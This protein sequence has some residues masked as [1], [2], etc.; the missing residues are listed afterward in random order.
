[1]ANHGSIEGTPRVQREVDGRR[2]FVRC[3]RFFHYLIDVTWII[4][5]NFVKP[6]FNTRMI[7]QMNAIYIFTVYIYR[8]T[9]EY[10]HTRAYIII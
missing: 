1:M 10:M 8:N 9:E 7:I 6:M 5:Y 4:T 2:L 3:G